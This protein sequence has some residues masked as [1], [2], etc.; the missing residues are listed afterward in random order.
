MKNQQNGSVLRY[1]VIISIVTFGVA[2]S[3]ALASQYFMAGIPY[4][5]LAIFLLLFVIFIGIVADIVGV[6]VTVASPSHFN[7]KAARRLGGSKMAIFLIQRADK[8]ANIC[9]DVIGDICGTVSG[10]LGAAIIFNMF[11]GNDKEIIYGALMTAS[12]AALTV[13]GKALG[14]NIAI[15]KANETIW[16]VARLLSWREKSL[17]DKRRAEKERE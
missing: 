10:G 8:V 7:A 14:K 2:A 12:V 17:D 6:A 3:L 11:T 4:I 13:G 5:S 16:V 15:N 1:V 9:N